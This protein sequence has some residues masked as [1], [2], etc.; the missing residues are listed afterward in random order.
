MNTLTVN[1]GC[2]KYHG[3]PNF[4]SS[5]YYVINCLHNSLRVENL[6]DH[7]KKKGQICNSCTN[8]SVYNKKLINCVL[9]DLLTGFGTN[10]KTLNC[11]LNVE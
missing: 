9:G 7:M 6:G 2:Q 8:G 11:L 5:G 4:I 10:D 3:A 1:Y